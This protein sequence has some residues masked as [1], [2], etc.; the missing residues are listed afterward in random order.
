MIKQPLRVC[1]KISL[2]S[3]QILTAVES[4]HSAVCHCGDNLTDFLG[5]TIPCNKHAGAGSEATFICHNIAVF[6]K[7]NQVFHAV[8]VR[9][10]TDAN[11]HRFA[12]N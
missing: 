1:Q 7:F 8:V 9:N 3:V 2:E 5:A 4:S 12:L 11:K 10:L 6:V